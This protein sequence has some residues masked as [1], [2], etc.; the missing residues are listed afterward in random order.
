MEDILKKIANES[1]DIQA[2]AIVDEEGLIISQYSKPN[3]KFDV[4]EMASLII[5]PSM[6]LAEALS[7]VSSEEILEEMVVFLTNTVVILYKLAYETYL[8]AALK[9]TPLYGKV[10]FIVK[11]NLVTLKETL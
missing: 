11:K 8:V 7:D 2:L 3:V 5:T 4:E 1:D 6:R 10:R 9:K